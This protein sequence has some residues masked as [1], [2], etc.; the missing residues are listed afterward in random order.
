MGNEV[1]IRI[2]IPEELKKEVKCIRTEQ[3]PD[4]SEEE[5]YRLAIRKG[6]EANQEKK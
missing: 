1:T 6:L 3:F 2:E 4:M 5:V